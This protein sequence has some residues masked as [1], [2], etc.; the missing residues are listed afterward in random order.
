LQ[1]IGRV[2]LPLGE[3]RDQHVGAGHL[4]TAGRLHVDDRALNHPLEASSGLGILVALADQVLQL[5]FEVTDQTAA[6]LVHVDI[7][8]AH[9]GGPVLII[10]QGEQEMLKGRVF[11]VSLVGER[12]G[13][14]QRLL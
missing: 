2:A 9:D 4:L 13:A 10:D 5:G 12:Q 7:T 11:V 14:V 3:D 1:E 8:G 6:Q